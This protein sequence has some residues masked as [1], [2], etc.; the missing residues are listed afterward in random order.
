MSA[1]DV[2]LRQGLHG[3]FLPTHPMGRALAPK[4]LDNGPDLDEDTRIHNSSGSSSN[5]IGDSRDVCSKVAVAGTPLQHGP[6]KH[7][8]HNSKLDVGRARAQLLSIAMRPLLKSSSARLRWST[9]KLQR[10]ANCTTLAIV[11]P[12]IF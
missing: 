2:F 4:R 6:M 3:R 10:H 1:T 8:H 5:A 7:A 12:L 9:D 11:V